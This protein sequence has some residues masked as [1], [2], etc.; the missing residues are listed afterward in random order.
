LKKARIFRLFW[1]QCCS[2]LLP[3]FLSAVDRRNFFQGRWWVAE[4]TTNPLKLLQSA[5]FDADHL[6]ERYELI[7]SSLQVNCVCVWSKWRRAAV[8]FVAATYLLTFKEHILGRAHQVSFLDSRHLAYWLV[9]SV[10]YSVFAPFQPWGRRLF[11][12]LVGRRRNF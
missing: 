12:S 8:L 4:T 5:F 3:F 1:L 7:L 10:C 6:Q 2:S 11:D 9:I